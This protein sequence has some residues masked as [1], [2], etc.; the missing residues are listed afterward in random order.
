MDF[1]EKMSQKVRSVWTS[2]WH[3]SMVSIRNLCIFS[4]KLH[5]ITVHIHNPIVFLNNPAQIDQNC[6]LL[7][8]NSSV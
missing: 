1:H 3:E 2:E 6:V 4:F 8:K 5:K 7:P